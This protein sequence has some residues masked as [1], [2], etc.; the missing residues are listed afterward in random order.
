MRAHAIG[1]VLLAAAVGAQ[2][3]SLEL[4]PLMDGAFAATAMLA[5]AGQITASEESSA[6]SRV[7]QGDTA[8]LMLAKHFGESASFAAHLRAALLRPLATASP[9]ASDCVC[10]A[11]PA[12]DPLFARRSVTAYTP[13][14][15]PTAVVQRALEAAV[16]APNHFLTEPW[17]F[18]IAGPEARAKLVALNEAKR[19]AFDKVCTCTPHHC[20]CCSY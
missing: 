16:L 20:A 12:Y 2:D 10:P 13:G 4:G 1:V 19:E 15:V 11:P 14:E 7:L 8:L 6:V 18:Y 9:A 17:R 3:C 5:R